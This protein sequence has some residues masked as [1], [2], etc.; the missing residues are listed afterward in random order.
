[1]NSYQIDD[2]DKEVLLSSQNDQVMME[3]ERDYMKASVDKLNPSGDVLEIGFGFGYSATQFMKYPIKSYTIIECDPVVIE[4]IVEW[5]KDYPKI[6]MIIVE[7]RW[8]DNLNHLGIFDEIYFDD[9]P[10]DIDKDSSDFD[11]LISRKRLNIFI[12]LCIQNHTKVGSKFS[13]YHNNNNNNIILSSDSEPF[14]KIECETT[15]TEVPDNCQYRDTTEQKC[16]IPVVTKIAEYDFQVASK[17]AFNLI[18][19]LQK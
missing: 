13:F 10:L 12:D 2:T 18:T 8:Q 14:V 6:P 11:K 19:S 7:G 17:H 16:L 5:R 4:K 15:E 1:M 9:F 3:W